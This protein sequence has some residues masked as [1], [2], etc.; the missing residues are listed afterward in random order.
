MKETKAKSGV[1]RNCNCQSHE[2]CPLQG[3]CLT[4]SIVYKAE[5]MLKESQEVKQYIGMTANTF[6][7]IYIYITTTKSRL[8]ILYTMQNETELYLSICEN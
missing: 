6:K 4:K 1:Q 7:E 2:E 3:S 8:R 5:V